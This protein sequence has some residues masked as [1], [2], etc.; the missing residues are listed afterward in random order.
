MST[1]KTFYRRVSQGLCGKCGKPNSNGHVR[2]DTCMAVE[3]EYYNGRYQ[4]LVQSH[5][6]S[7]CGRTMPYNW[8]YVTCDIC[9]QKHKEARERAK[10]REREVR[11]GTVAVNMG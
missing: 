5:R 9:Q 8:Y 4:M 11:D 2:C 10:Q 6:C 3:R 7:H 1:G